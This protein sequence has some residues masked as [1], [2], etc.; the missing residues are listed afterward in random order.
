MNL[1]LENSGKSQNPAKTK[2]TLRKINLKLNFDNKKNII[3]NI[4]IKTN[5]PDL[6]KIRKMQEINISLSI[7]SGFTSAIRNTSVP[8][9][10]PEWD[11][12]W[13]KKVI[14]LLPVIWPEDILSRTKTTSITKN[15]GINFCTKNGRSISLMT[16]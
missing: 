12:S 14:P 3:K 10:R 6:L 8:K 9:A 2:V 1:E 5:K 13:V 15:N 11:G 7:L 16:I 4:S